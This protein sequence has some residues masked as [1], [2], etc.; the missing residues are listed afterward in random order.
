MDGDAAGEGVMYG[1]SVDVGGLPVAPPL[2][3]IPA[4]VEVER[5][6]A[7]LALLAHVLQLHVGQMHG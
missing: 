3:H 1:E 6:A 5:V 4:H 7:F 2:V